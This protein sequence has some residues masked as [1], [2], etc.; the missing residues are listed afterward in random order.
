MTGA[1]KLFYDNRLDDGTPEASDTASGGY[2]VLN[3]RDWRNY[4]WWKPASVPATVTVNCGAAKAADYLFV[5][6]HDL[7][8]NGCTVDVRAST[9]NFVTS[10]V[11]VASHTP[12]D[13]YPF[14]KT[15]SSASYQYWRTTITGAT[16]PSVAICAVGVALELPRRLLV[17][18]DPLGRKVKSKNNRSVSGNPLGRVVDFEQWRSELF[19]P[20]VSWSWVRNTFLPAWRSHLM[21]T[22][23]GFAWDPLDHADEI[24]LVTSADELKL[25]HHEGTNADLSLEISGLLWK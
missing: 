12:T 4:T 21:D 7:L 22:P 6:G 8:T 9:D 23:F 13:D 17:G 25:P 19:I 16:A 10:N 1:A 20:A 11:L 18:F 3:L 14:I 24:M 2:S 15:F 5:W